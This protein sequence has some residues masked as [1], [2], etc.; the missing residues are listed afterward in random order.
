MARPICFKLFLL[1]LPAAESTEGFS[2]FLSPPPFSPALANCCS[3][4]PPA[5]ALMRESPA[6]RLADVIA[7]I[8]AEV[9]SFV[10]K[11]AFIRNLLKFATQES[12]QSHWDLVARLLKRRNPLPIYQAVSRIWLSYLPRVSPRPRLT[13]RHG[14]QSRQRARARDHDPC[15]GP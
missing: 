9:F 14:T 12:Y 1:R 10:K 8:A 3:A 6:T 4:L 11:L 5:L 2:S 7:T 13:R 15:C